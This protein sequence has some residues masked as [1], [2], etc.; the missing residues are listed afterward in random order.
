M[1]CVVCSQS[2]EVQFTLE[3]M[4]S[5]AQGF[6]KHKKDSLKK[7]LSMKLSQCSGCGLVQ[8]VGPTVPYFKKALR[9]NKL[10]E[11][12]NKYRAVQFQEFLNVSSKPINS[13]FELGAGQGEHLDIFGNLGVNT[14]G[15]EGDARACRICVAK[16]HNVIRGFI[17]PPSYTKLNKEKKYDALISF[18]FIEHLPKPRATLLELNEF[19]VPG[20]IALF[21][22]PNF[23]MITRFSLF[24]E[25]IPDHRCYFTKESFYSLLSTSGF[26]IVSMST[27]WDDYILSAVV[28]KRYSYAWEKLAKS[29]AMLQ[30]QITKFFKDSNREENA[31]WSAGHQS[32]ST[33]SN[34]RLADKI[35][36]V[37]DSSQEKQDNFAPGAGLPI[38]HPNII[39][40][41]QIKRV[42]VMAAGYNDEVIEQLRTQSPVEVSLAKLEKGV[43]INVKR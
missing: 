9:S 29:R 27:I 11:E 30:K 31:V 21:E 2:L 10:S 12:L 37:I 13:V 34:L 26:D 23:D 36:C 8:Y 35:S 17:G 43:V 14:A 25:F 38:M 42:L 39:K 22:V 3:N 5:Q 16:G 24:N 7:Q 41:G 1:R 40:D 20:G 28:K 33:I 19:L 15:V 6:T 18:N 4:P 32:L